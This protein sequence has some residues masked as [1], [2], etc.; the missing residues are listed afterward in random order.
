MVLRCSW[1]IFQDEGPRF[2]G[3]VASAA[4]LGSPGACSEAVG[5]WLGASATLSWVRSIMVE[6]VTGV[7]CA[8]GAG[9]IGTLEPASCIW[10]SRDEY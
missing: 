8:C 6:V 5:G 7:I 3:G 9:C 2:G 1:Q 4:G 10:G